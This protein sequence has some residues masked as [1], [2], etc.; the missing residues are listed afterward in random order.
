MGN[1]LY[2]YGEEAKTTTST[3]IGQ[4]HTS[5]WGK[6]LKLPH[7]REWVKTYISMGEGATTSMGMGKSLHLYGFKIY[8]S[9]G[10]R[11][12]IKSTEDRVKTWISIISMGERVKTWISI[13]ET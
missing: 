13:W 5:L 10:E 1:N 6:E 7:L 12:K 4:K 11:L 2:L 8:V 3:G 9:I